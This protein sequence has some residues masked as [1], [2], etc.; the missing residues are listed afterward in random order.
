MLATS[1][2]SGGSD[3]RERRRRLRKLSLTD[4]HC[5][6][7]VLYQCCHSPSL[8]ELHVTSCSSMNDRILC[9]LFTVLPSL[10]T[11][12]LQSCFEL[13]N[14]FYSAPLSL[15]PLRHVS[16]RK[17]SQFLVIS[18]LQ[19]LISC[20]VS[21]SHLSSSHLQQVIESNRGLRSLTAIACPF[22]TSLSLTSY[23][24]L[25]LNLQNNPNL[26]C[27]VVS[28]PLLQR[29]R[30][31]NCYQL[32]QLDLYLNHLKALDLTMLSSLESI[33]V[34]SSALRSLNLSGCV[35]LTQSINHLLMMASTL[36]VE[37]NEQIETR[38]RGINVH[39][40]PSHWNGEQTQPL[41]KKKSG[42]SQ[43]Y[44]C[45]CKDISSSCQVP[46]PWLLQ[47]C[48]AETLISSELDPNLDLILHSQRLFRPSYRCFQS[49]NL[50]L[51]CP[52]LRLSKIIFPQPQEED[53]THLETS[54]DTSGVESGKYRASR[55]LTM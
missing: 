3:G 9:K 15:S 1:T 20:D 54:V 32:T 38:V 49:I 35:S 26:R 13:Q 14:L 37:H 33:H 2:S 48:S 46:P 42:R 6:S 31:T 50:S 39:R 47:H 25:I 19:H 23:S 40:E 27:L 51:C 4:I 30:V 52:S 43:S 18:S 8:Q 36:L 12:S 10:T 41:P 16:I 24:L 21:H 34:T 11:L 7:N 5:S 28:C 22:L 53:L 29:L 45:L 17:C 44:C 55:R